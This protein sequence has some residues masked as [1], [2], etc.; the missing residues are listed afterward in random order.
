AG[1]ALEIK[2][3]VP[4]RM[5]RRAAILVL[6]IVSTLACRRVTNPD[7]AP[8]VADEL[9]ISL[10]HHPGWIRDKST[11]V[12]DVGK[13][14]L[15]MRIVR[16]EQVAGL[17]RI[18]VIVDPVPVKP[19]F[20]EDVLSRALRDMA[21]YEQ[22]GE[23]DILSLDQK[24]LRI[25]P[26]RGFRVTHTYVM[27]NSETNIGITQTSELFV[28]DGRGIT[29]TAAGRTEL[30]TPLAT[31]IDEIISGLTVALTPTPALQKAL[32]KSVDLVPESGAK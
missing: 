27:A 11:H 28:L 10:P 25:G 5:M 6:F 18:D 2:K 16:E 14:G 29:V 26:R 7:T 1:Q 19:T 12:D 4:S 13:G 32:T 3:G 9:G 15:V 17:P 30:Y 20:L 22:K 21:E 24:P 31:D 23:I 8:F